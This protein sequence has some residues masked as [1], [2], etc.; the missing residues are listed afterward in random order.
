MLLLLILPALAT[1]PADA[2]AAL[3]KG[4]CMA[5]AQ[6]IADAKSPTAQLARARCGDLDG[7]GILAE[8][9]SPLSEWA[10]SSAAE[11]PALSKWARLL[12]ARQASDKA[13]EDVPGLLQEQI[14]PGKAGEEAILL[15]GRALVLLGKSLEARPSLRGL[16][17]GEQG[18]E[19]RYW[20][21]RGAEDRGDIEAAKRTYES[22]WARFPTSPFAP[23]AQERLAVLGQSLPSVTTDRSREL[24]LL[25]ARAL[26][27][28]NRAEDAVPLFAMLFEVNALSSDKDLEEYAKARFWARDYQ[29]ALA[30]WE[31]LSPMTDRRISAEG[32]FHYALAISRAGDYPRAAKAYQALAD[33]FPQTRRGDLASF[34]I[35]Y[36]DYDAGRLKEAIPKLKAHLSRR[37]NSR[38]ADEARWFIA[39]SHLRLGELEVAAKAMKA[40]VD[41]H[42]NSGLAIGGRYW[43]ARIR[44][45]QGAP[46][47]E[48]EG[49]QDLLR[50]HPRSGYAYFAAERLGK[51]SPPLSS[52]RPSSA[53]V[54]Q[55]SSPLYEASLLIQAGWMDWARDVL[56]THREA[57]KRGASEDR[58]LYAKLLLSAGDYKRAKRFVSKT[59]AIQSSLVD[60][61]IREICLPRPE[62]AVVTP[63][64]ALTGLDPLLPYAIMTAE[65]ALDPSVTSPAGA[66]GLMQLMPFL[67][68]ELHGILL[69][70]TEYDGE[71]LYIPGYNAWFG[72]TE[73][74]R[75]YTRFKAV[76]PL[77][78]P[79][80]I[81]GYNGGFEAVERW[82][83]VQKTLPEHLQG[84]DAFMENIGYTETRRYVRKVLGYLMHYREV[85]S[86][87]ESQSP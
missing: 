29:G 85:Y 65:S 17:N 11:A 78:L 83:A 13:P 69:P 7:L 3:R 55:P 23:K 21:S 80:A 2:Q 18:P 71:R 20:L 52:E 41:L 49:L 73:L 33:R 59:C 51:P 79:M 53:P 66:R 14:Y 62:A 42:P 40:L 25:R 28:K 36:L 30:V 68:E 87:S 1:V 82:L 22:L 32:F 86:Q 24:T 31:Q 74:G 50:R 70:A 84:A 46:D 47:E 67:G 39:W 56:G 16:L 75:L 12:L 60:P 48:T 5:F 9:S 45:L 27:K 58:L 19:A 26:V 43:R 76:E 72:T 77:P 15:R 34:K 57:M 81:A 44:G 35:G 8:E 63:T 64:A 37:P 10:E 6:T 61:Q 4:D 54:V 38:H